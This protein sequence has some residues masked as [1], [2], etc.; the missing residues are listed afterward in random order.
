MHAQAAVQVGSGVGT[1]GTDSEQVQTPSQTSDS[2]EIT[3]EP[4]A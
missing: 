1:E 2:V 3:A 4:A